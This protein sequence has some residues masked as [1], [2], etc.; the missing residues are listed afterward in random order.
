M[1]DLV[2]RSYF[3]YQC[4]RG[5]AYFIYGAD[6]YEQAAALLERGLASDKPS[7]IDELTIDRYDDTIV[8]SWKRNAD[9]K[10]IRVVPS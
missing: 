10:W 3:I 9:R 1:S 8:E 7:S 5:R 4:H 2:S 6:T